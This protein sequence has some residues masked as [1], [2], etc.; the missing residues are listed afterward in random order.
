MAS[1]KRSNSFSSV[2]AMMNDKDLIQ[3]FSFYA[4]R[5][6]FPPE[7][8]EGTPSLIPDFTKEPT[9]EIL[10]TYPDHERRQRTGFFSMDMMKLDKARIPLSKPNGAEVNIKSRDAST[11][12][13][14]IKDKLL[15][16]PPCN[17]LKDS[18]SSYYIRVFYAHSPS[19]PY[20]VTLAT[21]Y[22]PLPL[23]INDTVFSLATDYDCRTLFP[24]WMLPFAQHV[25]ARIT[26]LW[27]IA[28]DAKV[29]L[30]PLI[31]IDLMFE[32][33]S[34]YHLELKAFYA[35]VTF[36]DKLTSLLRGWTK[37][38][39]LVPAGSSLLAEVS[40]SRSGLEEEIEV[41]S[42]E[43]EPPREELSML[44]PLGPE[45][46]EELASDGFHY[47]QL[48]SCPVHPDGC[49]CSFLPEEPSQGDGLLFFSVG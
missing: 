9:I 38:N 24:H 15:K 25:I 1:G 45:E 35:S 34:P 44:V 6:A 47:P 11:F 5:L 42:P 3:E 43:D 17:I 49:S 16:G 10:C 32:S 12:G 26:A 22:D 2:A 14:H 23:L 37:T 36:A 30:E 41:L 46:E 8:E 13:T 39:P 4:A 28:K 31:K 19:T 40:L 48:L 33:P 18:L 20:Y 7:D 27:D 29:F 21:N